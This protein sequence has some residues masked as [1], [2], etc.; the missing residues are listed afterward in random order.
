MPIIEVKNLSKTY[1]YYKKQPGLWASAKG[2][3]RREKIA[4]S[5]STSTTARPTNK[6][7]PG[8]CASTS[9]ATSGGV[10]VYRLSPS[11][12]LLPEFSAS[13]RTVT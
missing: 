5:H 7:T 10:P 1:E 12:E 3:F 9:C 6:P 8:T 2:L 11:N 13:P 4:V